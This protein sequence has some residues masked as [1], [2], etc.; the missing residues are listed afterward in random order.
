LQAGAVEHPIAVVATA[1]L[2]IVAEVLRRAVER[3]VLQAMADAKTLR[4]REV[5]VAA[6]VLALAVVDGNNPLKQK[7]FI[8]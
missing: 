7:L 4:Q 6:K 8:Y 5:Q 1:V 3:V 2:R